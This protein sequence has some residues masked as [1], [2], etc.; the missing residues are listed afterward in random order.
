MP[1]GEVHGDA[2]KRLSEAGIP[3]EE[4]DYGDAVDPDV[5]GCILARPVEGG[6]Q[7]KI[8]VRP[9][10]AGW[11]RETFAEWAASRFVRFVEHGPEPDGWQEQSV[12]GTWQL[13]GR[14]TEMPTLD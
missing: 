2:E 4:Q 6:T 1:E 5:F 13:W 9:E 12:G 3:M 7:F 10:L 8:A 11:Q 14:L